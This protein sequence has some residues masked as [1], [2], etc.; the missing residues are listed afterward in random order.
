MDNQQ[1]Q[2][3]E[4][5]EL[6]Q[7][8]TEMREQLQQTIGGNLQKFRAAQGLTREELVDQV[9][10]SVSFYAN[11]ESGKRMMSIPTLCRIADVLCVSVDALLY[12]NQPE[13]QRKNIE[14]LLNIQTP[15]AS[16]LSEKIV[17]LITNEL[18]E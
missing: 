15:K 18:K 11:L 3:N 6:L 4:M 10:I 2:T 12:E 16:D 7:Q 9:G 1:S 13:A 5:E 8:E 14:L 17:R